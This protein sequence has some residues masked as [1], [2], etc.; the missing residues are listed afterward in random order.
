[1]KGWL[2]V[3]IL[4]KQR[5]AVDNNLRNSFNQTLLKLGQLDEYLIALS[6]NVRHCVLY[7]W[8]KCD[9]YSFY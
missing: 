7:E 9:N 6:T 5:K 1:M 8:K 2:D 3:V 4:D